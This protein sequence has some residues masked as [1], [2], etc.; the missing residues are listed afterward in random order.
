MKAKLIWCASSFRGNRTGTR[1]ATVCGATVQWDL[2]YFVSTNWEQSTQKLELG[3]HIELIEI[4]FDEVRDL[5]L[6][7]VMS[8]ERSALV[9]LRYLSS[10]A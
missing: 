5:A 4:G 3:E 7:G 10:G 6:N 8:E 1:S 2:L 9:L